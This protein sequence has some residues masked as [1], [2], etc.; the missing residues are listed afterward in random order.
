[1]NIKDFLMDNYIYII[2]V[3]VL[4]IVTVI[5]FLADKQKI[6]AKKNK[7][8]EEPLPGNVSG[9]INLQPVTFQPVNNNQMSNFSTI[10][11]TNLM[12]NNQLNNQNNINNGGVSLQNNNVMN[13]TNVGNPINNIPQP[14]EPMAVGI[15]PA[16]EPM[17]QPLSEQQTVIAPTNQ[18]NSLNNLNNGINNPQPIQNPEPLQQPINNFIPNNNMPGAN[19]FNGPIVEPIKPENN[20]VANTIGTQTLNSVNPNNGMTFNPQPINPQPIPNPVE[21]TIPSPI[22]PPQPTIPGPVGFVYGPTTQSQN[23]N[24]QM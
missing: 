13:P 23:N 19:T 18:I 6:G 24:Q 17:Y 9:D 4:I 16:P 8:A 2:I 15:A 12:P 14:V 1:M 3:I 11:N 7:T 10:P 22:T 5:G 21:N 20:I